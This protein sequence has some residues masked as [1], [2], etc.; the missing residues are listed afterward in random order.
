[1][2][3]PRASASAAESTAER[4]RILA[5]LRADGQEVGVD[6]SDRTP[7]GSH[8]PVDGRRRRRPPIGRHACSRT[9]GFERW[10]HWSGGAAESFRRTAGQMTLGRTDDVTTVVRLRWA[11]PRDRNRFD[12]VF[13]PTAGDWDMVDL[14]RRAWWGYPL[15]RPVRLVAERAGLRPRHE[16][17]L[18]PYLSTPDGLIDP[19]LDFAGVGADDVAHGHRLRRRPTG[20]GRRPT[21]RRV[22]RSA[23]SSRRSSSTEPATA[24]APSRSPTW[25]ASITPTPARSI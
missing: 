11:E 4:D 22:G 13:R 21:V 2:H 24:C 7:A 3:S 1:M 6:R 16:S 19:L 8:D 25:S 23:S 18:G 9:D 20:G 10:E 14:P 17:G 12:R 5:L 15:V